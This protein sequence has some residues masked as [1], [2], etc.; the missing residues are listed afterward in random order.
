[1]LFTLS[2]I[3]SQLRS[4]IF[5]SNLSFKLFIPL[6]YL[7]MSW[8]GGVHTHAT[9]HVW[10]SKTT[11]SFFYVGVVTRLVCKQFNPLS[12]LDGPVNVCIILFPLSLLGNQGVW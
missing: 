6:I 4:L 12:R 11:C 3:S 10:M 7:G 8:G 2:H 9:V 1:M 5:I